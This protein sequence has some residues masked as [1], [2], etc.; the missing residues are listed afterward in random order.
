MISPA[1]FLFD[2]GQTPKAWNEKMLNDKHFKVIKYFADSKDIFEGVEIKGG[3]A[4]TLRNV[5]VNFNPVNVFTEYPEM[6]SII[7]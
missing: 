1:R 7:K 4:I 5:K 3:I 2:A 6:N